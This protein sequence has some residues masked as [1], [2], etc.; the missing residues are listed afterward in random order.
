[1][2]AMHIASSKTQT[3]KLSMLGD[4]SLWQLQ[5]TAFFCSDK[6][7]AGS[8]LKSYDWAAEM[9]LTGQCVI[10]GF[11]SK[12]EKD[13][14]D[15]LMKANSPLIW[16][17]ARGIFDRPPPKLREYMES[18]KWLI[19]SPFDITIKRTHR[20]IAFERNQF[21]ADNSDA[22]VFA[23]VRTG[24]MLEQLTIGENKVVRILD[25]E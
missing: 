14:F 15:L 8:V 20:G 3:N 5:K 13:V 1:M 2:T 12:I 21:I 19:V 18:G 24:G 22:L 17:I 9:K 10:S 7:S 6:F 23:H 25:S 16:V 4:K 11:Q